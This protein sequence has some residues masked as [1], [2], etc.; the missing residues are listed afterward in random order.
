MAQTQTHNAPHTETAPAPQN[1]VDAD[2]AA[3]CRDAT[4][5]KYRVENGVVYVYSQG[6]IAPV[7]AP[8]GWAGLDSLVSPFLFQSAMQMVSNRILQNGE[9]NVH[10]TIA[11]IMTNGRGTPSAQ[12]ND[13]FDACYYDHIAALIEGLKGKL[14]KD[15]SDEDKKARRALIE[16]NLENNHAKHFVA[17]VKAALERG[18]SVP[19]TEKKRKPAATSNVEALSL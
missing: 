3:W 13:A 5:R 10:E 6:K 2:S 17:S 15:A 18:K 7:P 19:T 11:N 16:G 9:G 1:G 14:P 12:S 8:K 4:L